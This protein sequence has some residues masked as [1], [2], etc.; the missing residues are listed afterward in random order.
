MSSLQPTQPVRPQRARGY[1]LAALVCA[2]A[3]FLGFAPT[4]F[5]KPVLSSPELPPLVHWHGAAFTAW[6]VLFA[7]QTW[8]IDR[9][10]RD[11]HRHLGIGG[12]LLAA[13]MV[14]LGLLTAIGAARRGVAAPGF[15][16][17]AFMIVPGLSLALFA[18]F[19]ALGAAWRS[20]PDYH[21]RL[22][23]LATLSIMGPALARLPA[24]AGQPPNVPLGVALVTLFVVA[25]IALDWRSHRRLH[26]V[27][28]WGGLLL[29]ASVPARIVIARS[30]S[31]TAIAHRIVQSL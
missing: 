10:R 16:A 27:L 29:I 13:L 24:L 12:L 5:L 9:R 23:L 3:T 31:W 17:A 22:M 28:L 19:V 7:T 6:I 1:L 26:P 2:T 15:D 25:S 20:R 8:L 4:Y 21:K 18:T 11:L 14:A 30:E